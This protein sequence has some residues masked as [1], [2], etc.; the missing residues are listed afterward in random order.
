MNRTNR[1]FNWFIISNSSGDTPLHIAVRTKNKPIVIKLLE[2]SFSPNTLNIFGKTPLHVAV[3]YRADSEIVKL[4]LDHGANPMIQDNKG[5]SSMYYASV[6]NSTVIADMFVEMECQKQDNSMGQQLTLLDAILNSDYDMINLLVDNRNILNLPNVN[7]NG[8][9]PL[10]YAVNINN[11]NVVDV[12][13]TRGANQYIK[14]NESETPMQM[15]IRL[16]YSDIVGL[17]LRFHNDPVD[18][19]FGL[20]SNLESFN[21]S[22]NESFNLST[23]ELSNQS[24]NLDI[25]NIDDFV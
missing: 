5:K 7:D 1:K 12:L 2:Y 8:N 23:N 6:M 20:S 21:L 11:Y 17:L 18:Q 22:T 14:N 13:L 24:Y 3:L 4:L 25:I 19:S 9:T 10:H 16:N 15:A